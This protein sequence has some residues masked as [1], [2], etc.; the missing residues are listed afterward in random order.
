MNLLTLALIHGVALTAGSGSPHP[1][2]GPY[3][4]VAPYTKAGLPALRAICPMIFPI[5]GIARYSDDFGNDRGAFRHTG[6]DIKAAKMT[7]IVAPFSGTLGM[8]RETFWIYG[9]NG[10]AVLGTHLN[11]DNFGKHDHKAD[12]DMMFA[13]N[14]H[15]DMHVYAGQFLG[16]VGESGDA[17]APHLHF[18]LYA[19][20]DGLAA[21]RIRDPFPS[22][23]RAQFLKRPRYAMKHKDDRPESREV[24]LEGCIRK[25][26]E[27]NRT[28]TLLLTA[29]QGPDGH[30]TPLSHP[31]YKKIVLDQ[32]QANGCGGW[33]AL[34]SLPPTEIVSAYVTWTG[35]SIRAH[36]LVMQDESGT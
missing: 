33:D 7:P 20:G 28:V 22:L 17:T 26:D 18:E 19:P 27:E 3:P 34:Q 1:E 21:K 15:A 9:D 14:L 2:W 35:S 36:R 5:V 16:Y 30:V 32:D 25:V 23:K 29:R 6:I 12:R 4:P 10:W 24:R 8:K 31:E 11:D 13:P